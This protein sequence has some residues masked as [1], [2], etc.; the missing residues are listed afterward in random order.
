MNEVVTFKVMDEE[1]FKDDPMGGA[2]VTVA[3]LIKTPEFL[4]L[5]VVLKGKDVGLLMV[6]AVYEPVH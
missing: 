4:T 1:V 3:E 6:N 2:S 5:P